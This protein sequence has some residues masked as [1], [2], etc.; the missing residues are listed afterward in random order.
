VRI[1]ISSINGIEVDHATSIDID[2]VSAPAGAPV[3]Q[4]VII[5]GVVFI[6]VGTR[7]TQW[8]TSDKLDSLETPAAALNN[9]KGGPIDAV[10]HVLSGFVRIERSLVR[11]IPTWCGRVI[12]PDG[13]RVFRSVEDHCSAHLAPAVV[14]VVCI[15]THLLNPPKT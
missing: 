1:D 14:A 7:P 3:L 11:P 15:R 9:R 5:L 10:S 6:G 12:Y 13:I 4:L 8:S 2:R